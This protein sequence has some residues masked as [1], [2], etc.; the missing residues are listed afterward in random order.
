MAGR[1]FVQIPGP[2][3]LPERVLRAMDRAMIDHRGAKFGDML[4]EILPRLLPIFG[5]RKGTPVIFS[6]TG[7]A[8]MEAA[9]VNTLSP[10]DRVLVFVIG[11]FSQAYARMAERM[12]LQVERVDLPWGSAITEAIVEQQL[13]ADEK[14]TIRA[15]MAIHNETSTGVTVDIGAVR[16]GMARAAHPALLMVDTISGLGS[17][18][19][20]FDDWEV[21]VA[22]AGSQKG[23]MLPPGLAILCISDKALQAGEKAKLPRYY[24]DWAAIIEQNRKG[25]YPY[26]PSTHLL[27]GLAESLDMLYEE[28]LPQ[29]YARHARLAEGI[30]RA[31]AAWKLS[32]VPQKPEWA[33]NSVSA[34][35][36]PKGEDAD[37]L[38]T[39]AGTRFHIALGAGLGP[40]QG[41]VFR[42]GH[43][44]ALNGVEVMAV[45]GGIEMALS[46]QGLPIELGKGVAAAQEWFLS[47]DGRR[48]V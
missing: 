23:L 1:E 47:Q 22:I 7:T 11:Q 43:L 25:F 5:S 18:D 27:F 4:K 3:N 9:L 24:F 16:R 6:G 8:G 36:L 42:I 19:F 48:P 40:L 31:V 15:V 29:V 33:S 38:I 34:I 46:A 32:L 39:V 26:T 20:D 12:G 13:R 45:L 21:D 14:R 35:R 28:G 37:R 2:T 41:Q 30:R 10:G 17:M 44:G